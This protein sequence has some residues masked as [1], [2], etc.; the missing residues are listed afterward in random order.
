MT[1][2]GI[3]E[4]KDT[5]RIASDGISESKGT[6]QVTVARIWELPAAVDRP[7]F[8]SAIRAEAIG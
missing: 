1:S 3:G 6:Y 7:P 2:S 5:Y 4:P 8:D